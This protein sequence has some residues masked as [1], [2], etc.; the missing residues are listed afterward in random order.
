MV[1]LMVEWPSNVSGQNLVKGIL[2]VAID[3]PQECR[4]T[5]PF[6]FFI[7]V[8]LISFEFFLK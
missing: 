6:M 4:F 1:E 3:Q 8:V 2:V 5:L 7:N